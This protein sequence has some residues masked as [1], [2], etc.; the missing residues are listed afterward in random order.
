MICEAAVKFRFLRF[1]Q[2]WHGTAT[3]NAVPDG[4][5]QLDLLINV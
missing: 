4:R 2:W 1:C 5:N 3:H